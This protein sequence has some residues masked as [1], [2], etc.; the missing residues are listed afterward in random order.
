MSEFTKP[1]IT[2]RKFYGDITKALTLDG[3]VF[4]VITI[5]STFLFKVGQSVSL[6]ST[7]QPQQIF[8]VKGV[9]S[10]TELVVG[11]PQENIFQY[12]DMSLYLVSESATITLPEQKRQVIHIN[13]IQRA[14]YE[15]EPTIALRTHSVDH[16][17][18]SYTAENPIPIIKG[19]KWNKILLNRDDDKDITEA[20]FLQ[21]GL[22]VR[23][24]ILTYDEDKDLV[25]VDKDE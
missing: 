25:E 14:V 4:G 3:N 19:K 9:L 18:R 11:S 8:K 23:K 13:E 1:R 2:E 22:E 21:D 16:L 20:V 5:D 10:E 24:Y 6:K 12:S 17:G 7:S 15:E